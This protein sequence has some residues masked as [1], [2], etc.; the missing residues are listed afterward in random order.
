M[1]RVVV[2]WALYLFTGSH[3]HHLLCPQVGANRSNRGWAVR[4]NNPVQVVK[5]DCFPKWLGRSL[6]SEPAAREGR[7]ASV[8]SGCFWNSIKHARECGSGRWR[9]SGG[10]SVQL[11]L[12]LLFNYSPQKTSWQ[13]SGGRTSAATIVPA[14]A[15]V[16]VSR[17]DPRVDAR[18]S[19]SRGCQRPDAVDT[20]GRR[21]IKA[22]PQICSSIFAGSPHTALP[23]CRQGQYLKGKGGLE[24][25]KPNKPKPSDFSVCVWTVNSRCYW[26]I[27]EWLMEPCDVSLHQW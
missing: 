2:Y 5:N 21:A 12:M 6:P 23:P 26:L 22:F 20:G 16:C 17:E 24:Q 18:L 13:D 9:T 14:L 27:W 1:S 10:Q 7:A 15:S 4:F 11:L 3:I 8:I 25:S 19:S